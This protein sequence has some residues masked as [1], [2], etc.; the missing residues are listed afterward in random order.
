MNIPVL[1]DRQKTNIHQLYADT[2]CGLEGL[3]ATVDWEGWQDWAID[4]DDDDDDDAPYHKNNI[5]Y[6]YEI[7]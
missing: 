7:I 1:A 3:R 4:D 6:N 5:N 2:R